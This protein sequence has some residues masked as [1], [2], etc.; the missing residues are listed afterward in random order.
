MGSAGR[1]PQR[2]QTQTGSPR[3]ASH[4]EG[5]WSGSTD[6]HRGTTLGR[7]ADVRYSHAHYGAAQHPQVQC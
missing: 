6:A 5:V 3:A 7:G 2:V 4:D 1:G